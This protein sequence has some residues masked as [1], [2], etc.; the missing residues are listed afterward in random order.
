MRI[1]GCMSMAS[2]LVH[3]F[4]ITNLD[5]HSGTLMAAHT[6]DVRKQEIRSLPRLA[7]R[8]SRMGTLAARYQEG[9]Y[10]ITGK[11]TISLGGTLVLMQNTLQK[12]AYIAWAY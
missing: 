6:P 10:P 7:A 1:N 11:N 5:T 12:R 2:L 3:L 9:Y 4:T 8:R